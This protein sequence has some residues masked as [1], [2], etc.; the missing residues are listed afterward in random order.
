MESTLNKNK[1]KKMNE[2]EA[3]VHFFDVS[4]A[5]VEKNWK[6]LSAFLEKIM[7]TKI[8]EETASKFE[9]AMAL[10]AVQMQALPKLLPLPQALRVRNHLMEHLSAKAEEGKFAIDLIKK[11]EDAWNYA[12]TIIGEQKAVN[13]QDSFNS[14]YEPPHFKN[15]LEAVGTILSDTFYDRTSIETM[16]GEKREYKLSTVQLLGESF[17]QFGGYWQKFLSNVEL[18]AD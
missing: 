9:Y 11:Y 3:A 15:P 2:K 12:K 1:N 6:E 7:E 10:V 8:E 4:L 14:R 13:V 5:A 18:T 16:G 17:A